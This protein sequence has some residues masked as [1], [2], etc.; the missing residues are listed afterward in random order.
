MRS[1]DYNTDGSAA[2]SVGDATNEAADD[3]ADNASDDA[4]DEHANASSAILADGVAVSPCSPRTPLTM[5]LAMPPGTPPWGGPPP[6]RRSV[7]P[8][9]L[10]FDVLPSRSIEMLRAASNNIFEIPEMTELTHVETSNTYVVIP[11]IPR[12]EGGDGKRQFRPRTR[13]RPRGSDC[14]RR[15]DGRPSPRPSRRPCW[16]PTWSWNES[17]S[18]RPR[19]GRDGA[20][21]AEQIRAV[22]AA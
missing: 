3:A 8:P 20:V 4:A 2:D 10:P 16:R 12:G 22:E 18:S 17:S 1:G 5:P 9:L 13:R 15:R 19:R 7:T 11:P 21:A 14:S 6:P